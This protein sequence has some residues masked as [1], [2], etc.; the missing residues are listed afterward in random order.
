MEEFIKYFMILVL[1]VG[2]LATGLWQYFLYQKLKSTGQKTTLKN[3]KK[4]PQNDIT[5]NKIL[6]LKKI[7]DYGIGA[8]LIWFLITLIINLNSN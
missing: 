7:G 6:L 3:I 5:R 1:V 2:G 4:L 8:Y